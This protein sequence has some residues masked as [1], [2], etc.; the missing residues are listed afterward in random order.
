M[1]DVL[2]NLVSGLAILSGCLGIA[3]IIYSCAWYKV[4][5]RALDLGQ[6]PPPFSLLRVTLKSSQIE[7]GIGG[8]DS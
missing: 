1:A 2:N 8:R 4:S 5:M 7:A 6:A 3:A